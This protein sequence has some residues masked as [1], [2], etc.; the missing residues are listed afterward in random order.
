MF[1]AAA[2]LA[3]LLPLADPDLAEPARR[4]MPPLSG[5]G[6][7]GTDQLGRDVLARV[8]WGLRVSLAVGALATLAAAF[9][10]S[11]I[12]LLA[13]FYGRF[14]DG[15]LMRLV[16]V[17]MAFPYLLLALGVVATLGPG[18]MNAAIAIAIA[19]VPFFARAVRGSALVVVGRDYVEAARM[20]GLSDLRIL[21]AEVL[22]NVLPLIVVTAATTIGWMILETAGLSFLGLGAQP[23]Q[24]DLGSMLGDGRKTLAVAPHVAAVPGVV[25]FLLVVGLNLLGDGLR[26][27]L[28]PRMADGRGGAPAAATAVERP[29]DRCPSTA[30]QDADP[31]L[32]VEALTTAFDL[33]SGR[34][35]AVREVS[36]AL[37]PG[38]S[39]GIVGES[40]SGKS[41]TA[42]SLARLVA[43][44][45][46]AI[47][48][49]RAALRGEDIFA[50]SFED[51]RAVRGARIAYVFQDPST[52]L[53]PVMAVGRQIAEAVAAHGGV[54]AKAAEARAREL[55]V[56]VELPDPERIF[57]AYPHELSG[58]QRQR[59]G[60]AMA[61]AAD[62]EVLIADEPTTALDA[63]TQ[64]TALR[65]F[66]KLRTERGAA[67]VFVSHDFSV[68][69]ALCERVAV[70]Y[71]GEI[72]EEGPTRE[73]LQSP[74][75]PYSARLLACAPKLGKPDRAL[76]AIEG[77]PPPID[78][79]P[80]GCSFAPRCR[81]GVAD[82]AAGPIA[83][84]DL[85]GGR[86][87]RCIR[88]LEVADGRY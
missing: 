32:A 20:A 10:G 3:P 75:H 57:S 51:L 59:V 82:C 22:P 6:L 67:L 53:N 34:H 45:P 8:V 15:A 76:E 16:D 26:D 23:P 30:T 11:A 80:Q 35:A 31:L 43:S 46:G 73:V 56:E 24:A 1:V 47:V 49:G 72:V 25:T 69:E 70:M 78:G 68:I 81:I 18:L 7:L 33:P 40:G 61:V 44:P 52:T 21:L 48:G 58:G 29:A 74:R 9:V 19:N 12:G 17:L 62:P 88:V 50:L 5:H 36:F 42:L 41:V 64:A 28:D 66:K 4:L 87:A 77:G 14:V 55:I 83:L 60:V 85:G 38:G 37:E 79:R 84:S 39:L 63:T 2:V 13:A 27:L 65:L 86:K 54:A 71:A